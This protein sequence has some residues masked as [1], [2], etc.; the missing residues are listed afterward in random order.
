[1]ERIWVLFSDGDVAM[2]KELMDEFEEK[3]A[4][5]V[6]ESLSNKVRYTWP[7]NQTHVSWWIRKINTPK[8]YSNNVNNYRG[9]WL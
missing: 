8:N 4:V 2:V 9:N 3:G 7:W 6:P 1:M 5:K